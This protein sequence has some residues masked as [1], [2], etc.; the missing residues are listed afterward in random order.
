ML[1]GI[2]WQLRIPP[3][4]HDHVF[5]WGAE[6]EEWRDLIEWSHEMY[7]FLSGVFVNQ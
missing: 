1:D 7:A 3:L 2:Q 4:F 6:P 5:V